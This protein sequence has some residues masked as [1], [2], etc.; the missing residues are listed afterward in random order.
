RGGGGRH[1]ERG[2]LR[3]PADRGREPPVTAAL[4][5]VA[6]SGAVVSSLVPLVNAELLLIGLAVA[7]PPAAPF[8][9]VVMAAGQMVGKSVLFLGGGRLTRSTLQSRLVRWRLDGRT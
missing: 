3:S 8:L 4:F 9:V 5:F 6:L 1:R 7:S 2:P